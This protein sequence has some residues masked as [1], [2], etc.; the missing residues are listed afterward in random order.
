MATGA[1]KELLSLE[2]SEGFNKVNAIISRVFGAH[3]GW[4]FKY[5]KTLFVSERGCL[6]PNKGLI[7]MK[8]NKIPILD[9]EGVYWSIFFSNIIYH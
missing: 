3:F 5:G 2:Y 1:N 6:I 9:P 8:Y 7:E 4:V